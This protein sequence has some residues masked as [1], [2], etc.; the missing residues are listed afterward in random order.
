MGEKAVSVGF[1]GDISFSKYFKDGWKRE[2]LLDEKLVSFLHS[3]DHV[4]AN[5]ECALCTEVPT[6]T[7]LNHTSDPAAGA[8]IRDR[9]GA[10]IWSIA[11]NHILDCKSKGLLDTLETARSFGCKT[12]GAGTCKDEAAKPVILEEAGGI[13]IF[14][15]VYTVKSLQTE[16]NEPGCLLWDD[17]ERIQKTVNA[18]KETCRW[19]VLVVHGGRGEFSQ[20]PLPFV[21]RKMKSFLDMG[22]DV[23]VAHHPHVVQNYETFG[24]KRIFYSLGNFIFDTDYQRAQKYTQNGMLLKLN[25]T[26][27][28]WD[29]E[30]Q[31]VLVDREKNRV[32]AGEKPVIFTEIKK[33]EYWLLSDLGIADFKA[34][35]NISRM[36]VNAAKYGAFTEEEWYQYNVKRMGEDGARRYYRGLK[37]VKLRLWKLARK[38]LVDYISK[39]LEI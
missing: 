11:N 30:Y 26:E 8:F 14:S 27:D 7:G 6:G 3:A 4:V 36:T 12:V 10:D 20:I 31:P 13:G 17:V 38:K 9:V 24:K 21:R 34:N 23:V 19:C 18:I 25:F 39:G 37:T 32:V 5:V 16:E 1:T 22:V 2:D 33:F 15:T 29:F 35:D 28:S